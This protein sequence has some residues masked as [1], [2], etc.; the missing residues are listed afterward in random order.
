MVVMKFSCMYVSQS[1]RVAI[2]E[3]DEDGDACIDFDDKRVLRIALPA[4]AGSEP[5]VFKTNFRNL[6]FLTE[7]VHVCM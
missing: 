1:S 6:R 7:L 3:I 2:M 4:V 5:W